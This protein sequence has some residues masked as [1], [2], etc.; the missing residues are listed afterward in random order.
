MSK[1]VS[2]SAPADFFRRVCYGSPSV[3]LLICKSFIYVGQILKESTESEGTC[4]Y[5][6]DAPQFPAGRNLLSEQ[7]HPA[8]DTDQAKVEENPDTSWDPGLSR[9][10]R[11]EGEKR[12]NV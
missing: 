1:A 3:A 11:G 5:P 10:E 2:L 9:L 4:P 8:G 12:N 7:T 6:P